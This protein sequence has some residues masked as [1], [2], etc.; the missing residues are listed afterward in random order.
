[1]SGIC[2]R[3]LF[4]IISSSVVLDLRNLLKFEGEDDLISGSRE[5]S[6]PFPLMNSLALR[7]GI[8]GTLRLLVTNNEAA[9]ILLEH[10]NNI[11][12][13]A[14]R[15]EFRRL[16]GFAQEALSLLHPKKIDEGRR[17]G[18][19]ARFR[20]TEFQGLDQFELAEIVGKIRRAKKTTDVLERGWLDYKKSPKYLI[21]LSP[22]WAARQAAMDR[23]TSRQHAFK[24]VSSASWGAGIDMNTLKSTRET[25]SHASTRGGGHS[26]RHISGRG[27][28]KRFAAAFSRSRRSENL[29]RRQTHIPGTA[30]SSS[31]TSSKSSTTPRRRS[32]NRTP[33]RPTSSL[34]NSMFSTKIDLDLN[35]TSP[36]I[37]T[38]P[39]SA[40]KWRHRRRLSFTEP[41]NLNFILSPQTSP[42]SA[43][44]SYHTA[45]Q[46]YCRSKFDVDAHSPL[47]N[48]LHSC[49]PHKHKFFGDDD[50]GSEK[51]FKPLQ[52]R[53][54]SNQPTGTGVQRD[55]PG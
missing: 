48:S 40:E 22:E 9:L 44:R 13:R 28:W 45:R 20:N 24:Q 19:S 36:T 55:W 27:D 11:E 43:S 23:I 54:H 53:R 29:T 6:A 35:Y 34:S 2:V 31:K 14:E 4:D 41:S 25:R 10:N 49:T 12:K 51:K 33:H 15:E 50:V 46:R 38:G 47:N 30:K 16:Q 52:T 42:L 5:F 17:I 7:A 8:L 39:V 32:F 21:S 1:M 37:K 26:W 18:G 3:F